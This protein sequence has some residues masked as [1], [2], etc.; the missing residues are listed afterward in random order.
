M[1]IGRLLLAGL[2]ALGAHAAPALAQKASKRAVPR[3]LPKVSAKARKAKVDKGPKLSSECFFRKQTKALVESKWKQLFKQLTQII[4]STPNSDAAKPEL[5]YRLSELYRERASAISIKAFE[6]EDACM[7]RSEADAARAA[8]EKQRIAVV[9][10]SKKFRDRAIKI[11]MHIVRNFPAYPRLDNVLYALAFNY[12]QKGNPDGAKKIYKTLIRKFPQSSRVP[13]TLVNF[14]EI[15]FQE[16]K[17]DKAARIYQQVI[18]NHKDSD[19][20]GYARYKLGWCHYN[21][22]K[23]REALADFLDVLKFSKTRRGSGR[24]RLALKREATR[25]IVRTYV[26]IGKASPN[27]AIRFFRKIAPER[28][29]DLAEKLAR[30]YGDTGQFTRSNQMYRNLIKAKKN[31]YRV[32]SYQRA[33]ADNAQSMG[34]QVAAVKELKRLVSLWRKVKGAKDAEPKRVAR[35]KKG[36]ELLLRTL[37]TTYHRQAS[38]TKSDQDYGV[39]Y[40]LYDD[41]IKTFP[42]GRDAYDMAYYFAELLMTLQKWGEA[43]KYYEKILVQQ[44]KGTHAKEAAGSAVVAYKKLLNIKSRKKIG[45]V[46][47]QDGKEIPKAKVIDEL[48]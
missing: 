47:D 11:Y 7:S 44:P 39:A 40:T 8:C 32:V 35:D 33:I 46:G 21:L 5:F 13:D 1:S 27:K 10:G 3:A 36:I 16:G 43:A 41:Y 37:A 12:Q 45:K 31:S 24:K 29:M 25:D 2:L 19:I 15:I 42:D 30:L 28:Y 34:K 18:A 9:N 48:Y 4:K 17:A 38:K 23:Y 6:E 22:G 14:G 20:Y 26:H